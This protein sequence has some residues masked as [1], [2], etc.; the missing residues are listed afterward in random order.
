M[1]PEVKCMLGGEGSRESRKKSEKEK[2]RKLK[3]RQTIL[4][5][6]NSDP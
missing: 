5:I 4:W 6:K 1:T 2:A 3:E